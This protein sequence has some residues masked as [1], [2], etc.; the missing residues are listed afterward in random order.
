MFEIGSMIIDATKKGNCSRFMNHS[1]E[2][3]AV[4]EKWY[5]PRTPCAI[6]RIGFFAKRDIE[7]GEEI[8]FDYQ[9]ENYGREAQR[10]FCGTASCTGWIGKPPETFDDDTLEEEIES[11]SDETEESGDDDVKLNE[12]VVIRRK[13]THRYSSYDNVTVAE[14]Q[15]RLGKALETGCRNKTHVLGWI[16]LMAEMSLI[17]TE[18]GVVQSMCRIVEAISSVDTSLQHI[19][20]ANGLPSIFKSWLRMSNF[21]FLTRE[22]LELK[23]CIIRSLLAMQSCAEAINARAPDLLAMVT[24]LV[25][26]ATPDVLS[27][28]DVMDDMLCQLSS[29]DQSDEIKRFNESLELRFERVRNAAIRL[30]AVLQQHVNYRIPK[31]KA[32]ILSTTSSGGQLLGDNDGR[33][34]SRDSQVRIFPFKCRDRR[35]GSAGSMFH[36]LSVGGGNGRPRLRVSRWSAD[37]RPMKRIRSASREGNEECVIRCRIGPTMTQTTIEA[38]RP[39]SMKR[40]C[41]SINDPPIIVTTVMPNWRPPVA[42]NIPP[43]PPPNILS[44]AP[45]V[46]PPPVPPPPPP[47]AIPQVYPQTVPYYDY[48]SY[49]SLSVPALSSYQTSYDYS[50]LQPDEFDS[51]EYRKYYQSCDIPML[52][53]RLQSLVKEMSILQSVLDQKTSENT[54]QKEVQSPVVPPTPLPPTPKTPP[55]PPHKEYMWRKAVDEDGA[56]YYYH[57]ETRESV[58]ELPDGEESDPGERTP[59]RM[60]DTSG[61]GN[62]PES[63]NIETSKQHD[64]LLSR[65]SAI[66]SPHVSTSNSAQ[67]ST[68]VLPAQAISNGVTKTTEKKRDRDRRVWE[69]FGNDAD[70]KRAKKLMCEIEKVVGPIIVRHIGHREDATKKRKEWII[71]QVSKEM[72]KRESERVDFNFTLTEKGAKR[73]TD[74]A[75]AFIQRKCA[76]EP[77][78][79]WKGYDGSP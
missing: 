27:V 66:C 72:L 57:K 73:V 45:I 34:D 2:P 3:N 59:T 79:L 47:P 23:H 21:Q 9:F 13:K 4:C 32:N 41:P 37:Y 50:Q 40:N 67:S 6:D 53:S 35:F 65:W 74:Y 36:R 7:L 8:T 24:D 52:Q 31:K 5:V 54:I 46:V 10:C 25:I 56:K 19:F 70:R 71:K 1:C 44:P 30:Q 14:I 48:G 17:K 12:Q 61:C 22:D 51:E 78:D 18:K 62:D 15:K 76:K 20:V 39:P 26:M 58:W 16:K 68:P 55:P 38:G 75:D 64:G 42:T 43:P 29:D 33:S 49:A 11:P 69:K 63:D 60:P 28:R 77:K